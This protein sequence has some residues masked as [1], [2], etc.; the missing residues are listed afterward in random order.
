VALIP[1]RAGDEIMG[2]L[3]INDRRRNRFSLELIHFFEVLGSSIGIALSRKQQMAALVRAN[4]EKEVLL[5]EIH[6]RVKNNL[7]IISSLL[8]LKGKHS[9]GE[10]GEEILRESQ[11]RIRAMAA[12]H[13]LL[14]KSKNFAEI[15]FGD[16]IREMAGQLFR[17]YNTSPETISLL[18]RAEDIKLSLDT[19]IPCGLMIN[20]LVTNALK[21]AFPGGRKGEIRIEMKRIEEGVRIVFADNGV[22]FPEGVDFHNTETLGLQLVHILVAQLGGAIEMYGNSGTMYVITLKTK[23]GK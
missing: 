1:L 23:G 15:N 14:Y 11:D 22:G 3:Q 8:R 13:S 18:I 19:A 12:V 7:Q 2:L 17:S 10:M 20:E 9:G 5:K 16:Y 6:H 4:E 21:Y